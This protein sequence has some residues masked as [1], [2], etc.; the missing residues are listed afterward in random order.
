MNTS[1][2]APQTSQ[3]EE[4]PEAQEAAEAVTPVQSS[5]GFMNQ[6]PSSSFDFMNQAPQVTAQEPEETKA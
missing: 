5:F 1:G 3:S 6:S 4:K 2:P